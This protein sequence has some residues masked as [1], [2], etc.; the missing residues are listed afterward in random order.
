MAITN[1]KSQKKKMAAAM[2]AVNA[3]LEQEA[4]AAR[5]EQEAVAA[6]TNRGVNIWS[7]SGR[8]EIMNMRQLVQLRT[9][10]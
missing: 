2:A 7:I 3:Y 9:F 6:Q 10:R 8:Q 5:L 1:T 4:E